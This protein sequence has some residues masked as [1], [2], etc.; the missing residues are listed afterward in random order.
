MNGGNSNGSV[1]CLARSAAG[2]DRGRIYA[3]IGEDDQVCYLADGVHHKMARPKKKNR[4]HVQMITHLPRPVRQAA[5]EAGLDSQIIHLLRV[6]DSHMRG[7]ADA[8]QNLMS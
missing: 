7:E 4:K 5:Q 2:H 6:Y 1:I 8:C 3:V